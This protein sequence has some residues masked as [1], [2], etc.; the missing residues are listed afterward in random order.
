MVKKPVERNRASAST[1]GSV[2][3]YDP[4]NHYWF[5][6]GDETKVFSSAL[7]DYVP[8]DDA[9]YEAWVTDGG[10]T[11]RIASEENLGKVLADARVRPQKA[12]VLDAFKGSHADKMVIQVDAKILL[13]LVNEMRGLKG[14]QPINGQQLRDFFKERM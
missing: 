12:E 4:A 14:Q 10:L 13:W 2:W 3:S 1:N 6:S 11:T 5:V 7:G 9:R 8:V